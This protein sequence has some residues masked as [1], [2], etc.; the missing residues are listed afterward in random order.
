MVSSGKLRRVALVRADVSEELSA[1]F[2]GVTWI[3]EVGTTIAVTSNR[4]TLRRN[5]TLVKE[6]LSSSETS[7]LTR[8]TRRSI[9]EN[10]ILHSHRREN[11][12]SSNV[13]PSSPIFV[14]LM[15]ELL[16][17]FETLVLARA[18][19]SNIPEDGVLLLTF[20]LCKELGFFRPKYICEFSRW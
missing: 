6:A 9:P 11:L 14:T 7:V 15:M 3:G 18:I 2:I 12:K 10:T 19:R 16:S 4:S 13:V 20:F 1:S 5:T 8:S 17:S